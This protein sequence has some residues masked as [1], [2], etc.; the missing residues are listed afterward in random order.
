MPDLQARFLRFVRAR[1]LVREGD[2]VLV[3]LSGGVDSVVLLHLFRA[4]SH[5]LKISV[6]AAHFDHAMRA[7]SGEDAHWV[8]GL[9]QAWELPLSLAR[10]DRPLYGE[11]D[12]RNERYRFLY[13]AARASGCARV[14]TAHH[15]DDQVETV[16]FRLLR[17]TGLRGLAGIPVRR[18]HI[19]RPLLR[20]TKKQ[21][22]EYA[23]AHAID[24][25]TDPTNEQLGYARNRIRKTV[26]PALET[27]QPHARSA[28]L[29]L[30]RYAARTEAAWHSALACVEKEVIISTNETLS[31]LARPVLLEYHPELRARLLRQMLRRHGFVPGR[32]QTR[33]LVQFCERAESGTSLLI[34]G[35]VNLE[36]AFD[37]I[38]IE[39]S[40]PRT[41]AAQ[42]LA[43]VGPAGSASFELGGRRYDVDWNTD[44][45]RRAG[46]V[47][48]DV[49]L[50]GAPLELRTWR[51]GDRIR[52]AYGTKKLKKLFAERRV[53]ASE[54]TRIP[55]LS[56]ERG[57][58]LWVVGVARSIDALPTETGPAL[59]V[60]VRH[61]EL[62]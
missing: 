51:P 12:A 16:L 55:V 36:R 32:A 13:D 31:E 5:Q 58:V 37:T 11:T 42:G 7:D 35:A 19:I 4:S 28:V 41:A 22:L 20:F 52:L 15:A 14:A 49:A 60:T 33:H 47:H 57:R 26:I 61:A 30:A 17:G 1:D 46:E 21:I 10:T 6:Q 50:S 45:I 40:Q 18:G 39:R 9:C 54:R 62:R 59:N 27:V 43:L 34:D 48:F 2:R 29:G 24:F 53:P 23:A 25:R 8:S 38:R 44:D 56:D 3:A